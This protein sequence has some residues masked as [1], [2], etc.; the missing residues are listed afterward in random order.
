MTGYVASTFQRGIDFIQIPTTLLSQVDASVGGKTGINN[1]YGK[2]LIGAFHQPKAVYIESDFLQTLP[3]REFAAGVAEIVKMAVTFDKEFFL[4]LT[5]SDLHKRENL[6]TAIKK[7]VETKARV[8]AMDEKEQGVRAVLNYGHTFAH[9]IENETK[10]K[11]YLHGEAVAIGMHMANTLA[12]KLGLMT[13]EERASIA[14]LLQRYDLPIDYEIKDPNAFYEGFFLDKKSYQSRIKFI[15]PQGIGG[16]SMRDDI[17]KSV[18]LSVLALY[19]TKIFITLILLV[20]TTSSL[21]AEIDKKA[22]APQALSDKKDISPQELS[23]MHEETKRY[24]QKLKELDAAL[25]KNIMHAKY[26][27]H[28]TYL[29]I[30][31]ELISIRKQRNKKSKKSAT[32]SP[33]L[34][35]KYKSLENQLELLGDFKQEPFLELTKPNDIQKEP[36]VTSPFDIFSGFAYVKSLKNDKEAYAAKLNELLTLVNLLQEKEKTHHNLQRLYGKTYQQEKIQKTQAELDYV[37]NAFDLATATNEIY[38]QKLA[39][40]ISITNTN[41]KTQ[42]KKLLKIATIIGIILLFSFLLKYFAKKTIKD[43]ERFYMAN[44]GINFTNLVLIGLVLLFSFLEN[45][46]YLATVLGFA[47]AGIA[48]AMKDLF[49]SSLGWLVIVFGGSFHVGD[50]VKV[51]KGS[52]SYVGDIVDI[53]FLRMTILEDITYTTIKENGRAGRIIFIPNNYIFTELIANYTHGKIKTV[54]DGIDIMITFDSNHKKATHIIKEIVKK[55]SKGYTDISR[56]QLNALRNQYSLKNINVE[57]RIYTFVEK[58]GIRVS[59]W[60]MTN[61]YA[62]LTLRSNIFANIIDEINAEEDIKIAYD[63][64]IINIKRDYSP[65]HERK[66]DENEESL[67]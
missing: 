11:R 42:I 17:D 38:K 3:S 32:E 12:L 48:I 21:V 51:F 8:V 28:Q 59:C 7:S 24:T 15:L 40:S 50:R 63:T 45:A 53:S 9:V 41:I 20:L 52:H 43:N 49:M 23:V 55:Y 18:V 46:T 58:S 62:T 36:K 27:N 65:T 6:A 13:E 47:S 37:M 14:A 22:I 1:Q 2:N 39:D 25:K 16:Y 66:K 56:K 29:Q 5:Q 67:S 30:E 31:N 57:P 26:T 61:S 44:K 10:Y 54:W 64:Q 60:Y 4:W 34:T 35:V 19:A 33:E